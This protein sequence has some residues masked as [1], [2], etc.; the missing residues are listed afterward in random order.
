[1]SEQDLINQYF[2]RHLSNDDSIEVSVG[3]DAAVLIPES[4]SKLIVTTDTLNIDQHFFGDHPADSLGHKALAVNLSDIAAMGAIPQWATLSLSLPKVDHT[5]LE[6]FSNGFYSLA[7]KYN[8]KL[9]GGDLVKGPLSITIQ[10]IG[11]LQAEP[12]LRS[13]CEVGDSVYVTGCLGDPAFGLKLLAESNLKINE[14]D[15]H[16][17]LNKL[18]QPDVQIE[19]SKILLSYSKA[20]ID[21]S[22]GLL[23]D[24]QRM[25]SASKKG[26]ILN[27]ENI[28]T[29]KP[30]R[31]YL[32]NVIDI[33]QVL[34][35]GED[36]QLLFTIHPDAKDSMEKEFG[37][38]NLQV[39]EIG[40]I[41]EGSN[42]LILDSGE[43]VEM[44][45]IKGFDHFA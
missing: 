36:Y 25:L 42:I 8:V 43:K 5:W 3:D 35:G 39:T 16:Y 33:N 29:S 23:I 38:F 9:I 1:M 18:Y 27:L 11:T 30:L 41:T 15:A 34:G 20:A 44:P 17:F 24:L 7:D 37:E 4:N 2:S 22:D 6:D 26:A 19:A 14:S 12:L 28:P 31:K 21:V 45:E 10:L 32:G 13:S 40:E